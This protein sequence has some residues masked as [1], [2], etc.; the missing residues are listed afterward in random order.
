MRSAR[1]LFAFLALLATPWALAQPMPHNAFGDPFESVTQAIAA[2]P[3]PLGPHY[4]P[5]QVREQA[6]YRSHQGTSCYRSG[7]CRLP[8]AYLYDQDIIPRV[9]Q[10]IQL[11]G[12]F[13][14]TSVWVIGERRLVTLLGC[15]QTAQQREAL[16]QAVRLVD[17]VVNVINWLSIPGDK[18]RY[19]TKP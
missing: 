6:H 4:T 18:P 14:D 9:V 16:E 8:N 10:Y 13:N 7:R 1:V 3:V 17:D 15:V 5:E 2:C 11:D 19:P 12:R